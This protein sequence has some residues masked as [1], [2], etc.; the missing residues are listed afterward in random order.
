MKGILRLSHR[1]S[2]IALARSDL[3][4]ARELGEENLR[5][6]RAG[7]YRYEESDFLGTLSHVEFGEG[8]VESALELQLS[9]LA[10][11]RETGG[12]AWGEPQYLVNIA[13]FSL[14]VGRIDDTE[15]Y[16][17]QAFELSRRIGDRTTPTY[18]LAVLALVAR[19][20]AM[21][22]APGACGERSRPRRS[23]RSSATGRL[24][25]RSTRGR[26]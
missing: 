4:R 7:G 21:P 18:A 22:R 12:W 20:A 26:S 11:V 15:T 1:L 2:N 17:R 24:I 13:E 25:A 19:G 3:A 9:A 6:A 14:A 10:I 8:N 16:A 5:R 23:A